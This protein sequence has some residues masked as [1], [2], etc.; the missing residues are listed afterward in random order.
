MARVAWPLTSH[1]RN[2]EA[3]SRATVATPVAAP[4]RLAAQD[5][6]QANVMET[7]EGLAQEALQGPPP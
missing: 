3:V 7:S 2:R 5:G 4:R 1:N 6:S